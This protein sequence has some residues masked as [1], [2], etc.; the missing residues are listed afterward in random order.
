MACQW[1]IFWHTGNTIYQ[2]VKASLGPHRYSPVRSNPHLNGIDDTKDNVVD[3]ALPDEMV[4]LKVWLPGLIAMVIVT[5]MTMRVGFGLPIPETLLSLF[6]SAVFS[7]LAIQ[8][9]GATGKLPH[10]GCQLV[11]FAKN[12]AQTSPL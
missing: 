7:F 3:P 11:A 1:R 9:T 10:T 5:C 8:A 2:T 12:H 4:P 6:L